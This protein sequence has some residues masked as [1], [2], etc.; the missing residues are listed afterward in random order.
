VH[1]VYLEDLTI[2]ARTIAKCAIA[3]GVQI[4]QTTFIQTDLIRI[5]INSRPSKTSR[6]RRR[7]RNDRFTAAI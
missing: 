3:I 5:S 2:F 4:I 6:A 7:R 1:D